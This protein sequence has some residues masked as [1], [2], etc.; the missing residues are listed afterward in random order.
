VTTNQGKYFVGIFIPVTNINVVL[1][2]QIPPCPPLAKWGLGGFNEL[3]TKPESQRETQGGLDHVRDKR[4]QIGE[5]GG[6]TVH[7]I[8]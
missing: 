1:S 4:N 5:A 7:N 3:E 6:G 8:W 2:F